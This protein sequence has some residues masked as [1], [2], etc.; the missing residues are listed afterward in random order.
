MGLSAGGG[1]GWQLNEPLG[2]PALC[3]Q[4]GLPQNEVKE[5]GRAG[6]IRP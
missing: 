6:S 3:T 2:V 4:W 5:P 1:A